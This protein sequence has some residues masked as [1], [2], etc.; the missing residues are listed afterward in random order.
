M[1]MYPDPSDIGCIYCPAGA[2]IGRW[3]FTCFHPVLFYGKRPTSKLFLSSMIS[4]D[5][6]ERNGHPCPKPLLWITWALS[7]ASVSGDCICDPLMGSGTTLVAAKN[8]GRKAIGIEIEEKY[9]AIAVE[10]LRQD[11]LQFTEGRD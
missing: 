2:G 11:V 9:C 4:F 6:S 8:L 7:L 5:T 3:G 1:F 10:R